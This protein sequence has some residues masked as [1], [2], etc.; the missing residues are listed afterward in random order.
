MPFSARQLG[1]DVRHMGG[2]GKFAIDKSVQFPYNAVT[3]HQ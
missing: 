1:Y 2:K 3:Y